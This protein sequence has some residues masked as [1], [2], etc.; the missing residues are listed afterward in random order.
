[1]SEFERGRRTPHR[2]NLGAIRRAL[3]EAG[4]EFIL[5]NGGGLGCG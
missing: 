4:A 3:E 2:N 1:M 5:E